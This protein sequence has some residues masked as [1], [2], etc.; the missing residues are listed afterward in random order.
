[1]PADKSISTGYK[2]HY[3]AQIVLSSYLG[4]TVPAITLFNSAYLQGCGKPAEIS[5]KNLLMF[6]GYG[7]NAA[8]KKPSSPERQG[9]LL[10]LFRLWGYADW[11]I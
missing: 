1:M 2:N 11:M 6:R 5:V 4:I 10:N 3:A 7:H 9:R 8:K